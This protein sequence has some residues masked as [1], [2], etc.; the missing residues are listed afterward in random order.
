[1]AYSELAGFILE[2]RSFSNMP[3]LHAVQR[4]DVKLR[5]QIEHVRGFCN[6]KAC[7][8]RILR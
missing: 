5:C 3:L 2:E 8:T 4:H 1:M 7:V 6:G